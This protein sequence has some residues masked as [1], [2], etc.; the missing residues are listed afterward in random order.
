MFECSY[1]LDQIL[2]GA[3]LD[4]VI[5]AVLSHLDLVSKNIQQD[6]IPLQDYVITKVSPTLAEG[7]W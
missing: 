7:V 3:S 4:E 1:V 6:K 2:S 5:E